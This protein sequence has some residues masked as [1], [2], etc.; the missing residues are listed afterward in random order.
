M[1]TRET[2]SPLASLLANG[3]EV[4]KT[5]RARG[6]RGHLVA[7]TGYSLEADRERGM[8]SGFDEYLVKPIG[9]AELQ[10]ALRKKEKAG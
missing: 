10:R 6:Y 2:A 3:H 5:L 4:A 8:S 9:L 7:L 1:A